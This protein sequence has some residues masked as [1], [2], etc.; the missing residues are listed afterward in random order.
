MKWQLPDNPLTTYQ[1]QHDNSESEMLPNERQG[2]K[3][4]FYHVV[5]S[6]ISDYL[7]TAGGKMGTILNQHNTERQK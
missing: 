1:Q 6:D 4:F 5:F 3:V 2:Q 7:H